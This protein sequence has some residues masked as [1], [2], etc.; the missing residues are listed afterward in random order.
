MKFKTI[1]YICHNKINASDALICNDCFDKL[2]KISW[3]YCGR[4]GNH[5]CY[6]CDN[7]KQFSNVINV[8]IYA[9]GLPELLVQAKDQNDQN[10]QYVFNHFFYNI[11]LEKLKIIME[12]FEYNYILLPPLRKERILNSQWHPVIFLE[13]IINTILKSNNFSYMPQILSPIFNFSFYRQAYVPSKTRILTVNKYNDK[14]YVKIFT[15]S[16][17]NTKKQN[18]KRILLLDDV[19][20]TGNTLTTVKE[21]LEENITADF[22]DVF[23][24]FRAIQ[25]V[26]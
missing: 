25:S 2:T 18:V 19:L 23:T 13:N 6:G 4:C 20:T 14:K 16:D 26:V 11:V 12:K 1:C 10:A 8:L 24:I 22:W 21:K 3:T 15:D 7:L 17:F 5:K 9:H